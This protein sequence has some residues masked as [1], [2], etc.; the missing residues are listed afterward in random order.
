MLKCKNCGKEVESSI[1]FDIDNFDIY[2]PDCGRKQIRFGLLYSEVLIK[3]YD[4]EN[5]GGTERND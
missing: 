5:K 4:K 1:E 2:C 3:T